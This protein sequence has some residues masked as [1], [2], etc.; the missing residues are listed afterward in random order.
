MIPKDTDIKGDIQN[1]LKTIPPLETIVIKNNDGS[2]TRTTVSPLGKIRS[3]TI[4][5]DGRVLDTK[6]PDPD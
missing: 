2:T 5:P 3:V 1:S 6:L 4:G